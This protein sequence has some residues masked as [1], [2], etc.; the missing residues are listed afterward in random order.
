MA[1]FFFPLP[2]SPLLA[3]RNPV[4]PL[5]LNTK[6]LLLAPTRRRSWHPCVAS[7]PHGESNASANAFLD[8]SQHSLSQPQP[9]PPGFRYKAAV[10]SGP[11]AESNIERVVYLF[12]LF[13]FLQ[14]G[15]SFLKILLS[16]VM[17]LNFVMV[18][19]TSETQF[20][21]IFSNG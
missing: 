13:F 12:S 3:S 7:S 9:D 6:K 5:T 11:S 21:P 16:W 20:N 19:E 14:A 15:F 17:C 1:I 4:R 2:S 8:S 10:H 18:H